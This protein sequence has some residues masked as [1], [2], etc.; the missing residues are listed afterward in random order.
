PGPMR[1]LRLAVREVGVHTRAFWRN[2]V[3][4]F[5]MLL[6][7]VVLLPLGHAIN[8]KTLVLLPGT[9][10]PRAVQFSGG[11]ATSVG[12][13]VGSGGLVPG[14]A[15]YDQYL[16]P[17]LAA[18][19]VATACFGNLVI[20]LTAAREQGVLKRLRAA[21]IPGWVHLAGRIG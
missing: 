8:S 14:A 12:A 21:P 11:T 13:F 9:V 20:R 7:P 10:T 19:G 16:V 17:V 18:F 6:L 3:A 5:G 2:P 1:E 15:S 4:A